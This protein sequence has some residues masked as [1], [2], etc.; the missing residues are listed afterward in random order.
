[1]R[2][3][4]VSRFE[5]EKFIAS[6]VNIL[7]DMYKAAEDRIT[8]QLN[9]LDITDTARARSIV[10]LGEIR[11]ILNGLNGDAKDW[12]QKS[13]PVGYERG[14]DIA[15]ER[16]K[17]LNVTRTTDFGAN[18]HTAAVNILADEVALDLLTANQ[19]MQREIGSYI[20][21]TQ[22]KILQDNRITQMVSE[23]IIA[24]RSRKNISDVLLAKLKANMDNGAFIKINGRNYNPKSYAELVARTRMREA[25]T[26]GLTTTCL[27]YDI[28]LVQWDIHSNACEECQ[29]FLGRVFS[30]TPGDPDFAELQERPPVHPNCECNLVPVTRGFLINRLGKDKFENLVELSHS[31][32]QIKTF[33]GYSDILAEGL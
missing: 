24:G 22:Q 19:S 27:Q 18:I 8:R 21:R 1:M 14:F 26:R 16:L 29:Q 33:R 7:R 20:L 17:I 30:I 6:K 25:T 10:I 11:K 15:S 5:R 9:R 4:A 2:T 13:I 23:G 3:F 32:L 28:N 31:D 12:A